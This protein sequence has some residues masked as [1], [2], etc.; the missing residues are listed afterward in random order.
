MTRKRTP[1]MTEKE[2]IE[3]LLRREKPDRVP[4]W[5]M[6]H[7]VFAM[8]QAGGTVTDTYKNPAECLP[9]WRKICRDFGWVS[10][11]YLQYGAFGAWEFGGEIKLPESQYSFAP[12]VIRYPVETPEEALQLKIPDIKSSGTIPALM[13]LSKKSSQEKPD[14]EPWNVVCARV[15]PFTVAANLPG[16]QKFAKWLIKAPEACHHLLRIATGYLIGITL[17]WKETF[18]ID[19]VLP[20]G[21]EPTAANQIIS[22]KQF[23]KFA[24]PYIKELQEQILSL[25]YKTT[26]MHICGEQNLNLPYWAQIPFGDP[27]IV[28]FGHEVTLETAAKYFPSDIIFGNLEPVIILTK[29]PEEVYEASRKV[30]EEGKSLPN[31]FIFSTGCSLPATADPENV[32]AMTRA[33]NDFGWYD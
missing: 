18:G 10:I 15:G 28:S 19:G 27:G 9:T 26:F 20:Y 33:I 31:G 21:A 1:A 8:L 4:F 17:Y 25:G 16:P 7:E 6:S 32:M 2:R 11:P 29:T 12:S 30:I 13:E 22:P 5:T 24:F 23:E 3:A 14:N